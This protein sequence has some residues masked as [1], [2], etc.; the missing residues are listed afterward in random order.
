MK[1]NRKVPVVAY[2]EAIDT[3]IEESVDILNI[4]AGRSWPGPIEVCPYTPDVKRAIDN[5]IT[6]VAAAGNRKPSEDFEPVNCP[7]AIEDVIAVGGLVTHCPAN[8]EEGA[9]A[10]IDEEDPKG[11]YFAKKQTGVEYPEMT[12]DGVYCGQRGCT[13]GN[14]IIEQ[15]ET[16]WQYN[17]DPTDGKPD[18]LAPF[19]FPVTTNT[20]EPYLRIGT[21]FAAPVVSGT[22][23]WVFSELKDSG[24]PVPRPE[25]TRKAV[26][27]AAVDV[28]EGQTPKLN[29]TRT[30]DVLDD[31]VSS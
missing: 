24:K 21:S 10:D 5:D 23:A 12:P 20:G 3:A 14:C 29:V 30:L 18:V 11:P 13:E 1:D 25:T 31:L 9:T 8:V 19:H 26:L 7:A 27:Q 4:S 28:D 15:T 17:P 16:S 2:K 6:V 22:L